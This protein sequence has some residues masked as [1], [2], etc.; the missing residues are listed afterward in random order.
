MKRRK[1]AD[2]R[3]RYLKNHLFTNKE[4]KMFWEVFKIIK[5]HTFSAN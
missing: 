3:V 4:L 2:G 5:I 1:R